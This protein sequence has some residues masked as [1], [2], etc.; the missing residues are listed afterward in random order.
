MNWLNAG[1]LGETFIAIRCRRH[2]ARFARPANVVASELSP[3]LER[4]TIFLVQSLLAWKAR[5]QRPSGIWKCWSGSKETCLTIPTCRVKLQHEPSLYENTIFD[6]PDL[7]T[8]VLFSYC[9]DHSD[10]AYPL[11]SSR[12]HFGSSHWCA[13]KLTTLQNVAAFP[14]NADLVDDV[15]ICLYLRDQWHIKN[16]ASG[17]I[18]LQNGL[19]TLLCLCLPHVDLKD[20]SWWVESPHHHS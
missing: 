3:V 15:D 9:Y 1:M 4:S 7:L 18:F 8:R 11:L 12:Q 16:I 10:R 5:Q 19:E 2:G 20:Q 17:S 13:C 14:Q 6:V